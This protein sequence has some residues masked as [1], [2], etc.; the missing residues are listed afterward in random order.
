MIKRTQQETKKA[1]AFHLFLLVL[2]GQGLGQGTE[3]KAI[4][5]PVEAE[6][7]QETVD[8][9]AETQ[10]AEQ[11]AD[12]AEHTREQEADGGDDLE[13]RLAQETPQGVELLLG[14][15]H[16]LQLALSAVN[17]LG[18]GTGELKRFELVFC[19]FFFQD[20]VQ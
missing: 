8:D 1:C 2:A 6:C 15:G 14:V 18:D 20:L 4:K 12:N 5:Q 10:A 19:Y 17:G 9:T 16:I 3:A 13:E 7:A 11:T